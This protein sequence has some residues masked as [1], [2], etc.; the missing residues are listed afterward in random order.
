MRTKEELIKEFIDVSEKPDFPES[1]KLQ[2]LEVMIDIRD[3]LKDI[4]FGVYGKP[5]QNEN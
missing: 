5:P 1:N 2:L 4:F 3:I